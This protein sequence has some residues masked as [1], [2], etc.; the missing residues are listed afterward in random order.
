MKKY[1]STL[2]VCFACL[3]TALSAQEAKEY[4]FE[5]S[6]DPR[7]VE[8]YPMCAI[9]ECYPYKSAYFIRLDKRQHLFSDDTSYVIDNW[10]EDNIFPHIPS[11][12]YRVPLPEGYEPEITPDKTA[13]YSNKNS[14]TFQGIECDETLI[15]DD[16]HLPPCVAGIITPNAHMWEYEKCLDRYKEIGTKKFIAYPQKEYDGGATYVFCEKYNRYSVILLNVCPFRYDAE[17]SK[18]YMKHKMRITVL[19]KKR[20]DMPQPEQLDAKEDANNRSYV[21]SICQPYGEAVDSLYR[22]AKDYITDM[23]QPEA[24]QP[25]LRVTPNGDHATVHFAPRETADGLLVVTRSDGSEAAR[26][27]LKQGESTVSIPVPRQGILLF[28]LYNGK[29]LVATQKFII[30]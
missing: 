7:Y 19:L 17:N 8:L 18:L 1:T 30:P 22:S 24:T 11:N 15:S 23:T 25:K 14:K 6:F 3:A 29:K 4:T 13:I 16:I 10:M 28:S 2:I 21:K 27:L 26:R 20:T 12:D 9:G 5:L